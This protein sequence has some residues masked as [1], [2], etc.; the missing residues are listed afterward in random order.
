M[1][2]QAKV[3]SVDTSHRGG[4]NGFLKFVAEDTIRIPDYSG[5]NMFLSL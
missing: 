4:M 1:G 3:G 2:T 5:N